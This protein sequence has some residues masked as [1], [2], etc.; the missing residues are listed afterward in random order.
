MARLLQDWIKA[1]MEYTAISEAPDT[2]HFWTAVSTIAGALRR[3]VYIDEHA[4]QWSPNFYIVLVAPPGVATK[5]TSISMGQRLLKR[6]KGIKF[7]PNN[8]TWQYLPQAMEEAGVNFPIKLPDG[9]DGF[10][11]MSALTFGASELGMLL[12]PKDRGMVDLLVD[13][14]DGKEEAWEK[15]TKNSGKNTVINPWINIIAATTPS[16]LRGNLPE[17]LVTGGFISRTLFIFAEKKRQLVPYP[18]DMVTPGLLDLEDA[19]IADLH[20]IAAI[21]G[22]YTLSA[23]AKEWGREW[24]KSHWANLDGQSQDHSSGFYA[25]Q[26]CHFHK[27]A[28]VLTAAKSDER[29]IQVDA[30]QNALAM[31]E[32]V[33]DS[34][35]IVFRSVSTTTEL[36]KVENLITLI[37]ARR[38]M[39]K[40]ALYNMVMHTMTHNEFEEA[41]A[42]GVAAQRIKVVQQGVIINL[43]AMDEVIQ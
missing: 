1:Y 40:T 41:I 37:Q 4:Y 7:G 28:I 11:P 32:S 13:L 21:E 38:R 22:R 19:L 23:E 8:L 9:S 31:T 25:R 36:M 24:Y 10:Y 42:A 29:V 14:W 2:F 18:S 34:L 30:L 27:L 35:P 3:K 39:S 33:K 43:Y 15:A 5:S 26:Q 6:V 20:E 16:W 17:T 12:D